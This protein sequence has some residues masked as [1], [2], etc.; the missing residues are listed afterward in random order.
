MKKTKI[1][2]L[3]SVMILCYIFWLLITG[4]VITIFQGNPS[5]EVLIAGAVVS[6]L[7]ALFSAR[8]FIHE[9]AFHLFNP[10]KFLTFLFYSLII[11]IWELIK[12][13]VTVA[14]IALKPGKL[15]IKP[16]IV[17]IPTELKS[18]YALS[19]LANSITLTPGTITL[20]IAEDTEGKNWYYIHWISVDAEDSEQAGDAIKGSMEPWIRRIWR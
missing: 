10:I 9:K 13:N 8:F 19:M 14:F 15:N 7:V 18:E 2:A 16:G 12:A 1:P 11:F 20:D 4:Q 6:F 5:V 17:K 3:I